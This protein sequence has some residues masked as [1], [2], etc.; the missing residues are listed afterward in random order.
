[1]YNCNTPLTDVIETA[2]FFFLHKI[3]KRKT[4]KKNNYKIV[5]S[6]RDMYLN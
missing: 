6:F 3:A 1:M 5:I 2:G 4:W